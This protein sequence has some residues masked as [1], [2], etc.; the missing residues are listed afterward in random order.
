MMVILTKEN[1]MP[2]YFTLT[3]PDA[4]KPSTFADIDDALREHFGEPPSE[5]SYLDGWY[6]TIGLALALGHSW[7]HMRT[8]FEGDMT[9]KIIDYLEVNYKANAWS[10]AGGRR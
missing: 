3:K 8:Y 4:D 7:E 9:L 5:D 1:E 2:N 10:Q 6:D